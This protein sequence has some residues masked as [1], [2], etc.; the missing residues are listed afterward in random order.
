[1][2]DSLTSEVR[3]LILEV[4]ELAS[5]VRGPLSEVGAESS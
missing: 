2:E 1:M 4:R 5:E 3:G